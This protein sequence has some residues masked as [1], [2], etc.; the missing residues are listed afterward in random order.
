METWAGPR[1]V[2]ILFAPPLMAPNYEGLD[3]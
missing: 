3:P 2:S 1:L